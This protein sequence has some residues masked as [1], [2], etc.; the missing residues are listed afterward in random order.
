MTLTFDLMTLNVLV[1]PLSRDQTMYQ[2]LE[3]QKKSAAKFTGSILYA[4]LSS[5]PV[6]N[7]QLFPRPAGRI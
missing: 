6:G 7:L 3:N 5:E 2:I 1:H 4:Q